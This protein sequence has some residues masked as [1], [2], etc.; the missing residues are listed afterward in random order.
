[1]LTN[2]N[3]SIGQNLT[4]ILTTFRLILNNIKMV[5]LEVNST[6]SV[7]RYDTQLEKTY[8][9]KSMQIILIYRK[10]SVKTYMYAIVSWQLNVL[11]VT[12]LSKIINNV[13]VISYGWSIVS[14]VI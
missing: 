2:F 13:I 5:K 1:M 10:S 14:G 8:H 7:Q 11:V 4:C 12:N 9:Q 6:T 3:W